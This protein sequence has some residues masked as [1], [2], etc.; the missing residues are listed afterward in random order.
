[1][2]FFRK[3]LTERIDSIDNGE[4]KRALLPLRR[5]LPAMNPKVFLHLL[6]KISDRPD[7][8]DRGLALHFALIMEL[9]LLVVGATLTSSSA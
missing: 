7:P 8:R 6:A 5:S 4:E 3:A 1:M 2:N 9:L